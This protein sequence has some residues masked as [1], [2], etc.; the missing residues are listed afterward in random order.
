M[1]IVL[2]K[3]L[4]MAGEACAGVEMPETHSLDNPHGLSWYQCLQLSCPESQIFEQ[5]CSSSGTER[6][7]NKMKRVLEPGIL[8]SGLPCLFWASFSATSSFLP[9]YVQEAGAPAV[10]GHLSSLKTQDKLPIQNEEFM[11]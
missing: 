6:T 1:S 4:G 5:V 7:Y 3:F 2:C 10:P 11:I 9:P 8:G